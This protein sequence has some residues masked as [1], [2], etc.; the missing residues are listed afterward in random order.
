MSRK[1]FARIVFL[2]VSFL[3]VFSLCLSDTVLATTNLA[4]S[5]TATQNST[6]STAVAA[7]AIDGNTDGNYYN[8]S[9]SHTDLINPPSSWQVDLGSMNRIDAIIIWNRTD[10]PPAGPQR[11]TNF[12]VSVL[13]A[14][15]NVVWSNDYFTGG[16]YPNPNLGIN[17]PGGTVGR[18]VKVNLNYQSANS[19]LSLAEVQVFQLDN[20][21]PAVNGYGIILLGL[22]GLAVVI[23]SSRKK[24]IA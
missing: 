1:S 3:A 12:K 4:L 13:D 9:V 22:A 19:Y 21:V 5:G 17:L 20:A 23:I 16:G 7:H 11:L 6:Y 15:Q 2:V 14:G 8:G 10:T 18:F 24:K